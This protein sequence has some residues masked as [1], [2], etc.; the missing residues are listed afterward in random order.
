[1]ISPRAWRAGLAAIT[2]LGA[3]AAASV[4]LPQTAPLPPNLTIEHKTQ[5]QSREFVNPAAR[6]EPVRRQRATDV[7]SGPAKEVCQLSDSPT[8]A[9]DFHEGVIDD[10]AHILS[11]RDKQ[12]A[13]GGALGHRITPHDL[14]EIRDR[15]ATRIFA[16][17]VL[18]RVI[19]PPQTISAGT[20]H[21]RVIAAK[22]ISVRFDGAD[23][24]PAQAKAEAYLNHLRRRDRFDLDTAQRWLLLVN[25]IPG[26]QANAKIVHSTTPG[27]P[28]EG[29]D[30]IVSIKRT[31][32]DEFGLISNSNAKTLGPWSAITRVDFNGFTPF[33]ERTSLIAYSTLG[34]NR[35]EVAQIIE[36]ARLGD[37]GLFAQASFAWGHSRPGDVLKELHLTGNSYV[38]T[39]E[40]DY[41]LIRL[42]RQNLVLS[43]GIDLVNQD[44]TFP[45]GQVL[46]NDSLRIAWLK[47]AGG[48]VWADQPVMDNLMT[49]AVDLSVEGRKGIDALG[50]SRS[51]GAQGLSRSEGHADAW[52]V[53]ADGHASLRITPNDPRLVP[54]TISGHFQGQWADR[55][56]L[57]YEDQSI[58]NLTI[59]RGYDPNAASGDRVASGE[60][61]IE[62]GP[63]A[64]SRTVRVTPYAFYDLA[65][66]GYLQSG[67]QDVTL[68]SLGGGLEIRFPYDKRG[69]TIRL[70]LGYA[71]PLDKPIPTAQEKPHE[72]FLVQMIIAH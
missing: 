36:T 71:K 12:T 14:C 4:A 55:V 58:G 23:V 52:V 39:L 17:G 2:V 49:T 8:L 43:T 66:V 40:L 5:Q 9:F 68:R 61:K 7:F 33:G 47:A 20:V 10:D 16:R 67:E 65:Y 35:Q 31:A 42:Q 32:I 24:G 56:L 53:R 15:L 19:I 63:M 64:L 72:R 50:A 45:G 46:A 11:E 13:W 69:H 27:A 59:G 29:L 41:P 70:D 3:V 44:T 21:F 38:G 48:I 57:A 62:V 1:M 26:I 28:P 37:S 51:G 18:A 30:L 54:I 6:T 34:N 22:I 25:D 60:L